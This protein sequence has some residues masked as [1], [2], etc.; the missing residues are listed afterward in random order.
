MWFSRRI[1]RENGEQFV[2]IHTV[3]GGF[4]SFYTKASGD[5]KDEAQLS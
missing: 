1:L 3:N 4:K 5:I 2:V